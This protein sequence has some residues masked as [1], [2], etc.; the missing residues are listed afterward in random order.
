MVLCPFREKWEA[1]VWNQDTFRILFCVLLTSDVEI[2][3]EA[4]ISR[5]FSYPDVD[6][7]FEKYIW[8]ISQNLADADPAGTLNS[9]SEKKNE[10]KY[11]Q[12]NVIEG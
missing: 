9:C 12:N 11:T 5:V 2:I 4:T 7:I 3:L 10:Q 1:G 8:S 6:V